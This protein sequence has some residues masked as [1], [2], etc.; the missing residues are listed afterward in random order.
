MK[1]KGS[2]LIRSVSQPFVRV[3]A[4]RPTSRAAREECIDEPIDEPELIVEPISM[5]EPTPEIVIMESTEELQS[6]S[7][8]PPQ[9][10][11]TS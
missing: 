5:A 6:T 2:K 1:K 7:V 11:Q 8:A 4:P 9:G 3:E 10:S